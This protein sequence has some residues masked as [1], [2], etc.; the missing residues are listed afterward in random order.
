VDSRGVDPASGASVLIGRLGRPHGLEGFIGIYVEDP[1][2]VHLEPGSTVHVAGRPHTVRAI[3]RGKKG[4][5]VAFEGIMDRAGAEA[6]RGSEVYVEERRQL[7]S[8]EFWP[9]QLVGLRVRPG[10]GTVVGVAHGAA[11]DRLV[12]ERGGVRFEVP[13]VDDLVPVVDLDGGFVEIVELEGLS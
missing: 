3:R 12:V 10:G 6:V 9:E 13:F 5:Q 4:H 2:L 8:N 1:D 11:Q 7:D